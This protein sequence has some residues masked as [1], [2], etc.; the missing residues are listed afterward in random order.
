MKQ[1]FLSFDLLLFLSFVVLVSAGFSTQYSAAGGSFYPWAIHQIIIVI[2]FLPVLIAIAYTNI[3]IIYKYSYHIFFLTMT[4]LTVVEFIGITRMGAT[5]WVKFFG[6]MIQPSE[7]A[8]ISLILALSK[9]LENTTNKQNLAELV[10]PIAITFIPIAFTLLQPSLGSAII[11]AMIAISIFFVSGIEKKYF[12]TTIII[13][14]VSIPLV[15]KYYLYDYQKSRILNFIN[16]EK[17]PLGAGYNL[18]QS[19]IAI[20]SGGLHGRGFL[21][22]SQIQLGFL[23]EKHTDFAF[24]VFTEEN[25]FIKSVIFFVLYTFVI[26]KGLVIARNSSNQFGK[27]VAS[28]T[29][30]FF[31]AHLVINCGMVMGLFPVVGIP[32]PL[33]SYGGSVTITAM[34]CYALLLSI[35]INNKL[36]SLPF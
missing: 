2:S 10:L 22:G 18:M 32:L 33:L 5:R 15:W 21:H 31:S 16:P 3:E 17:D 13:C 8:K 9:C 29:S 14:L 36:K 28:G 23:P 30:T 12:I 1:K 25:G 24:T 34:I 4:L 7:L 26:L 27:L 11:M 19:K 6:I 35:E 20:G